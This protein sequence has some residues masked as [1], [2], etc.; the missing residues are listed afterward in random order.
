EPQISVPLFMQG[1]HGPASSPEAVQQPLPVPPPEPT[2]PV[3]EEPVPPPSAAP[4]PRI[5]AGN[6]PCF[7]LGAGPDPRQTPLRA[8]AV[9]WSMGVLH[10]VT[11]IAKITFLL[12]SGHVAPTA[13][14]PIIEK[15][16]YYRRSTL[17]SLE[18]H[19]DMIPYLPRREA[20]VRGTVVVPRGQQVRTRFL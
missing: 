5:E 14:E 8:A 16:Q 6:V 4:V 15:D 7:V 9:V 17:Q 1:Q 18:D 13:A 10:Y 3:F 11:G 20:F 19:L 2:Q 12:Q